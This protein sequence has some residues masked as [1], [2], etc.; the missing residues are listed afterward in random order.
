VDDEEAEMGLRCVAA[1]VYSPSAEPLAAIS[2]SGLTSRV[3]DARLPEIG[4]VV[5]DVAAELTAALGGVMP[6]VKPG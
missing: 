3:T 5:R 2:V 6:A 4:R 1:V